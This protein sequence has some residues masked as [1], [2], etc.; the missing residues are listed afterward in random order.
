MT[1]TALFMTGTVWVVIYTKYTLYSNILSH[2]IDHIH[3]CLCGPLG[4]AEIHPSRKVMAT[5]KTS[6]T[7]YKN[8]EYAELVQIV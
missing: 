1:R 8:D 5:N 7:Q 4:T 2:F 3:V 6:S